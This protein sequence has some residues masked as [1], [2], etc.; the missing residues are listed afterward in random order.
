MLYFLSC[1]YNRHNIRLCYVKC[2]DVLSYNKNTCLKM[3][4]VFIISGM[5]LFWFVVFFVNS[6]ITRE[7]AINLVLHAQDFLCF[8]FEMQFYVII[9]L[10]KSSL[11]MVT[12]RIS[13]FF[14][15]IKENKI[16]TKLI[17]PDY[18]A[19]CL[20]DTRLLHMEIFDMMVNVNK[21]YGLNILTIIIQSRI[22]FAINLYSYITSF[23][24]IG[25]VESI[26]T[27]QRVTLLCYC[28]ELIKRNENIIKSMVNEMDINLLPGDNYKQQRLLFNHQ[29]QKLKFD[30]EALEMF[31]INLETLLSILITTASYLL[32]F[33]QLNLTL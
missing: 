20:E 1:A 7:P 30:L 24:V 21:I 11:E 8:M 12:H 13:N 5:H 27:F 15:M 28:S 23:S 16:D 29:V 31:P 9:L 33:S 32:L 17:L 2:L 26:A 6:V 25:L 22:L 19:N 4:S 3:S 18:F 14:H 10:V